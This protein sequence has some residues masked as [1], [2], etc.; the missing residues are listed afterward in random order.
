M[1]I[2]VSPQR[3]KNTHNTAKICENPSPW[4]PCRNK[5]IHPTEIPHPKIPAKKRARFHKCSERNILPY[6]QRRSGTREKTMMSTILKSRDIKDWYYFLR[7]ISYFQKLHEVWSF[8]FFFRN[9]RLIRKELIPIKRK[10]KPIIYARKSGN[11]RM[12]APKRMKN[13]EMNGIIKE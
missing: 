11:A 5:Y 2:V 1:T 4:S 10:R 12:T 7:R 13:S 3:I 6:P 9:A 8:S